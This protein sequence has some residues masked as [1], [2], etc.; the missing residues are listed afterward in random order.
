M[1]RSLSKQVFANDQFF[2]A[3]LFIPLH[4]R[5]N[6][7]TLMF[8]NFQKREFVYLDPFSVKTGNIIKTKILMKNTLQLI[9]KIIS[10]KSE[11]TYELKLQDWKIC[12]EKYTHLPDQK[13]S[14]N[15]GVYV[16]Y[17]ARRIIEIVKGLPSGFDVMD[18]DS[19]ICEKLRP[20]LFEKVLELSDSIHDRCIF[21]W[22]SNESNNIVY[23][24]CGR[25]RNWIHVSCLPKPCKERYNKTKK[26]EAFL[27]GLCFKK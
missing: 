19:E 18:T 12:N 13:D 7:Y 4:Y 17:Y 15:C 5:T 14:Y 25:C 21:C 20:I 27:C 2:K 22:S 8:L 24:E 3:P 10:K 23:V 9:K 26:S 11:V 6:H 1:R 16:I